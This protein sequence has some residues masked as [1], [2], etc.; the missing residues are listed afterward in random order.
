MQPL[1]VTAPP[2]AFTFAS[3]EFIYIRCVVHVCLAIR[4][5]P[6]SYRVFVAG[7]PK[8]PTPHHRAIVCYA[9]ATPFP[10]SENT[11]LNQ[12][13]TLSLKPSDLAASPPEP[14]STHAKWRGAYYSMDSMRNVTSRSI[15][16]VSDSLHV[17]V[18]YNSIRDYLYANSS[19]ICSSESYGPRVA[20]SVNSTTT[21]SKCPEMRSV[22]HSTKLV[23]RP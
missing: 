1:H 20:S 4:L 18:M 19:R 13:W 22:A 9:P 17:E 12:T 5:G 23:H 8:M 3:P 2:C 14:P 10:S 11:A 15:I 7:M 6:S 16:P 21:V